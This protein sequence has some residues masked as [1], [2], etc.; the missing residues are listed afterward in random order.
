M[1]SPRVKHAVNNEGDKVFFTFQVTGTPIPTINWYFNGAPVDMANTMKYMISETK[2][3]P[4]TRNSTLTIMNVELSDIGTYT[5]NATNLVSTY[6][7]YGEL[8]VKGK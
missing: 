5:C 1:V 8:S 6:T 3:N 7:G 4:I 2:F